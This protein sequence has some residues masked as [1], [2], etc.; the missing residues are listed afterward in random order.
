VAYAAASGEPMSVNALQLILEQFQV[1]GFFL[2]FFDYEKKVLKV[3]L[4]L[5]ALGGKRV[6]KHRVSAFGLL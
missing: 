3:D 2:G 6:S 4:P 1:E 5:C